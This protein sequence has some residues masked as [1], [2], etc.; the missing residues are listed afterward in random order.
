M[1]IDLNTRKVTLSVGEFANLT[2]GPT[3][4][5]IGRAGLWRAQLG[6]A[7]HDEMRKRTLN[8]DPGARFECGTTGIVR[9]KSWQI[10]GLPCRPPHRS[11]VR[12]IC[13]M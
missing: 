4:G 10:H 9:W 13:G 6:Q 2:F 5:D 7:W 12:F 1:Q 8:T 3:G 11:R